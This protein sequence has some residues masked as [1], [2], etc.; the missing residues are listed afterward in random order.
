MNVAQ[1]QVATNSWAKLQTWAVSLSVGCHRPNIHTS[2]FVLI[3]QPWG[4]YSL[5]IPWKVEGWVDILTAVNVQ[6]VLKAACCID[7]PEKYRNCLQQR[8][9]DPGT[10]RTAIWPLHLCNLSRV[11]LHFQLEL[12]LYSVPKASICLYLEKLTKPWLIL[13][14][15]IFRTRHRQKIWHHMVV[16]F[17]WTLIVL[18]WKDG[19][20]LEGV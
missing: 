19:R 20:F 5:T 15:I 18:S 3:T 4:W 13:I 14:L 6:S 8:W 2:H 12:R 1:H 11:G 7:F 17:T 10:S 9:F 16:E